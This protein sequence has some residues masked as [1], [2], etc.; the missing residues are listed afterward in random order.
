MV[1]HQ[2]PSTVNQ[3]FTVKLATSV[4]DEGKQVLFH[5]HIADVFVEPK[6]TEHGVLLTS[7][8]S[9]SS[10]AAAAAGQ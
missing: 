6:D 4:N 8:R 7:T 5:S 2:I 1:W 9:A 10:S 3:L